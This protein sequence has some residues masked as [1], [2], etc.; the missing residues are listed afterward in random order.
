MSNMNAKNDCPRA[1]IE[2]ESSEFWTQLFNAK[3]EQVFNPRL[4]AQSNFEYFRFAF[5]RTIFSICRTLVF[6][7]I[8]FLL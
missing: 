8:L 3:I 5:K 7:I 2:R 1:T 6:L 4:G